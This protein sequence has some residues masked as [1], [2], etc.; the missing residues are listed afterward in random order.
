MGNK[1]NK[2]DKFDKYFTGGFL[3]VVV[4]IFFDWHGILLLSSR[5]NARNGNSVTK[6]RRNKN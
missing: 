4:L 3:G 6:K 1:E 2:E 5:K